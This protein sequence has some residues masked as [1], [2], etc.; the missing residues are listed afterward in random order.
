M[1]KRNT[2]CRIISGLLEAHQQ[3]LTRGILMAKT[4]RHHFTY[5]M[6][7]YTPTRFMEMKSLYVES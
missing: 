1:E 2:L 6:S 7:K 5:H 4:I 3:V